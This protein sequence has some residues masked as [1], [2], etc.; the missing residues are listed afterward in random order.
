MTAE[1]RH[2]LCDAFAN[3]AH[4]S[5]LIP[6]AAALDASVITATIANHTRRL[7]PGSPPE[8]YTGAYDPAQTPDSFP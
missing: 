4:G 5:Y 1:L 3:A 2:L 6:R 8:D 7:R